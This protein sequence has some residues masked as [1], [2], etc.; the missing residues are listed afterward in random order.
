MNRDQLIGN[1][2][3]DARVNTLP[4]GTTVAS[5]SVATEER[6]LDRKTN[7]W[8]GT[9]TW[10]DVDVWE[11]KPH[12]AAL[13]KGQRV[14]VDGSIS[15]R[16]GKDKDGNKRMFHGVKAQSVEILFVPDRQ[17]TRQDAP[18]SKPW[19]PSGQV[20][21]GAQRGAQGPVTASTFDDDSLPFA[22]VI[23]APIAGYLA[24]FVGV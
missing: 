22:F 8:K 7:E 5:F 3:K 1:L 12:I 10:H 21:S 6:Y 20:P 19:Q 13:T 9:T 2:G 4:S 15:V 14:Y 23:L 11:P 24:Q 16:E 17:D 18:P